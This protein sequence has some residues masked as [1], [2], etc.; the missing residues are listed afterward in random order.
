MVFNAEYQKKNFNCSSYKV[1]A[2][3]VVL[4]GSDGMFSFIHVMGNEQDKLL[5]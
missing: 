4:Y 2:N 3:Y 5:A 1:M